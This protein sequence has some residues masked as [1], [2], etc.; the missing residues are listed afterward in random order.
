MRKDSKT[1]CENQVLRAIHAR[2]SI[3]KFT[4]QPVSRDDLRTVLQ[5]GL[6][7]P[8]GLGRYPMRFMV[9]QGED[10]RRALFAAHCKHSGPYV[11]GA[12][13]FIALFM[14]QRRV[15]NAMKD[16]QGMGACM[17]NML[18]AAHS[19]DLG[20]V[21][22]GEITSGQNE[23]VTQLNLDPEIYELQGG[24]CLGYPAQTPSAPETGPLED[25]LLEEF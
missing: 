15:Y 5:A 13:A 9:F 23:I 2:R 20:T 4:E 19:L 22:I 7:A 8:S 3:R 16:H 11:L 6:S 17:E 1:Y 24:I 14:D 18:L 10:A 25:Y 21:W 12:P